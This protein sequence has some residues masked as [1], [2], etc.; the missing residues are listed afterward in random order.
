VCCGGGGG[1][2]GASTFFIQLFPSALH[3]FS[4][5]DTS[6]FIPRSLVCIP[7]RLFYEGRIASDFEKETLVASNGTEIRACHSRRPAGE[8]GMSFP[9]ATVGH[10]LVTTQASP[11]MRLTVSRNLV[12]DLYL[13]QVQYAVI[14]RNKLLSTARETT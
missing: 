14:C 7:P 5:A 6:G 2:C 12:G 3:I 8:A 1:W 13:L 11:D 4:F 9:E 10:A